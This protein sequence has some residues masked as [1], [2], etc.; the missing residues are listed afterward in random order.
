LHN[1]HGA[2]LGAAGFASSNINHV[3]QK[4]LQI[5]FGI[6]MVNPFV[7]I[8]SLDSYSLSMFILL[9]YVSLPI[10]DPFVHASEALMWVSF[11]LLTMAV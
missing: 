9:A 11:A 8:N 2:E 5:W 1:I 7:T 3:R 4:L 6:P 10:V